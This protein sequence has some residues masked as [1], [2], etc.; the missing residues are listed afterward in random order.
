MEIVK[1]KSIKK[2]ENVY[3]RYDLTV[4]STNN[5]FANGILIHNT[6]FISGKLHVK[7][8]IKLPFHKWLWNKFVD[9]THLFKSH[10]ITDYIIEYGNVTSS[11]TVIKNQ[12]INKGVNGGFYGVDIWSEYGDLIYPYLEEGMTLY[13]E[14]CG[15]L[16][17]SQKMIQKGYDYGCEEGENFL[18]PYRIT[19][20]NEDG[21][22]KEWDV[23]EVYDWTVKLITDNPELKNRI[24]PITVAYH[25]T[26]KDLYPDLSLTEHWHENLLETLRNDKKR[27][28]MEKNCPLCK[29]KVP[30]EGIVLRI[31]G[32]E[33]SEAFKLKCMK[34]LKAEASLMDDIASGKE[35]LSDEMAETYA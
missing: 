11:R 8:P 19:T 22:K 6:S 1:I 16:T 13:G 5:F 29:N 34:F 2:L 10:R 28:N 24:H 32:D 18:M 9:I 35:Q 20:T 17:G 4:S 26:L 25:G 30:F 23:Q 31:D 12:Y 14:I 3:D 27:F 33:I 21:T 7:T 15:Y